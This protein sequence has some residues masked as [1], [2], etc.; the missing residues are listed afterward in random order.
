[1]A[2]RS[3][4]KL[5]SCGF[6]IVGVCL[7][8]MTWVGSISAVRVMDAVLGLGSLA[9]GIVRFRNDRKRKGPRIAF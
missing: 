1:M 7:L 2:D 9:I 3:E 6:V 8:V 4:R 5:I